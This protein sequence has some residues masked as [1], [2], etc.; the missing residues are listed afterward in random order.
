MAIAGV[1]VNFETSKTYRYSFHL[2]LGGFDIEAIAGVALS[3]LK[4]TNW[5]GNACKQILGT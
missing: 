1:E 2:I 4:P 5:H 3:S